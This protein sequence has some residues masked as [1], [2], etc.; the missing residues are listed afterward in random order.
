VAFPFGKKPT[1]TELCDRLV[2]LGCNIKDLSGSMITPEGVCHIMYACN[3]ANG[4]FVIL[5]SMEKD[6]L[7]SPWVIGNV[8]RSLRLDTGYPKL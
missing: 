4:K 2:S 5:P 7:V 8:E 3:P 1:L 6:E